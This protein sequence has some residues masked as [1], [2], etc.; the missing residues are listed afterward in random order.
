MKSLVRSCSTLGTVLVKPAYF[1]G[2][3]LGLC[4]ILALATPPAGSQRAS[5]AKPASDVLA[6]VTA[7]ATNQTSSWTK[8]GPSPSA[9]TLD[10]KQMVEGM[11]DSYRLVSYFQNMGY[12]LDTLREGSSDVPRLYL[13][14]L[15]TDLPQVES[16]ELRKAVFIKA[17]LP[18]ILRVNE[19]VLER[20]ARL[21]SLGRQLAQG[22]DLAA[23]DQTWLVEMAALYDAK[24]PTVAELLRRVDVVPPSLALAQAALESGWGTSRFAQKGNALFG[25]KT[26]LESAAALPSYDKQGNEVFRMRSFEDVLACV[27]SYVHNLNSHGAYAEFRKQRTEMRRKSGPDRHDFGPQAGDTLARTLVSYSER[28]AAYIT[29]VR[30]L[31]QIN[32]LRVFDRARLANEQFA[33]RPRPSA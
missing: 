1:S 3:G 33:G 12:R 16:A 4:L 31:M 11:S 26:F 21:E 10:V 32:D 29:D 17:V 23:A 20:R 28:G 30:H 18:I 8:F 6:K 2:I 14:T 19:E 15:P 7:K 25:Q 13:A 9:A 22:R 27:R 24:T 5:A